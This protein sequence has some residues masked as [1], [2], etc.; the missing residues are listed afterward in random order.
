MNQEERKAIRRVIAKIDAGS[1]APRFVGGP[2]A[3]F[4][5]A[6]AKRRD[7]AAHLA[8]DAGVQLLPGVGMVR[9]LS[10]DPL[11]LYPMDQLFDWEEVTTRHGTYFH[12]LCSC[13]ELL[14][15]IN[16]RVWSTSGSGREAI[17]RLATRGDRSA[18]VQLDGAY[19]WAPPNLLQPGSAMID[20]LPPDDSQA[21]W[22]ANYLKWSAADVGLEVD[23]LEYIEVVATP[24][25][26][27]VPYA[28]LRVVAG[29]PDGVRRLVLPRA[30]AVGFLDLDCEAAAI[31]P[32]L[33]SVW[34]SAKLVFAIL[35]RE[36]TDERWKVAGARSASPEEVV[37]HERGWA[38]HLRALGGDGTVPGDATIAQTVRQS[39]RTLGVSV[40]DQENSAPVLC[41]TRP[42]P[43]AREIAIHIR[44]QGISQG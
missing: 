18:G 25:H 43:L 26:T 1:P 37:L 34:A 15:L 33:V 38:E 16:L 20:D 44:L 31:R 17:G 30:L 5:R 7:L 39:L 28:A 2:S 14:T 4:V 27:R 42:D 32:D 29:I 22:M 24:E 9:G 6:Y 3:R 10:R 8:A 23:P 19:R 35:L 13:P 11:S 12:V 36:P 40:S 21:W 41:A